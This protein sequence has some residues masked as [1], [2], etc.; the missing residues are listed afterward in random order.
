MVSMCSILLHAHVD[1]VLDV[2]RVSE[3][4]QA[5]GASFPITARQLVVSNNVR[6]TSM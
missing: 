3:H 2:L 1:G 5:G 6:S 4:L